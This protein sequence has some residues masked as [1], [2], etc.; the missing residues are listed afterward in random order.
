MIIRKR[1]NKDNLSNLGN[2]NLKYFFSNNIE[3]TKYI[4]VIKY[5]FWGVRILSIPNKNMRYEYIPMRE[6]KT[7]IYFPCK[8]DD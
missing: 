7:N 3:I 1:I 2:V 4:P 5:I 6:I 8:E